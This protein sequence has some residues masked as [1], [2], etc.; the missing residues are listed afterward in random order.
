MMRHYYPV[1]PTFLLKYKFATNRFLPQCKMPVVLFHG[2]VDEV[3]YYGSS[4]K[5]SKLFKEKDTLIT[6]KGAGHNGMSER[7]DYRNAFIQIVQK[8]G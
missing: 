7:D 3:I 4:V 5:L 8:G 2:D 6:L 1:L